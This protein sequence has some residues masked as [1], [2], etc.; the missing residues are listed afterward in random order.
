MK[1]TAR[2]L[3]KHGSIHEI[4]DKSAKQIEGDNSNFSTNFCLNFPTS[5]TMPGR[6]INSSQK[7]ISGEQQIEVKMISL[8]PVR[9]IPLHFISSNLNFSAHWSDLSDFI[10]R[11]TLRRATII[12]TKNFGRQNFLASY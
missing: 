2:L 10:E 11:K 4:R 7:A 1:F 3:E 5:G 12:I 6:G 9:D 8:I